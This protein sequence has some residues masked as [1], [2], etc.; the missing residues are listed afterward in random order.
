MGVLY[1]D[2]SEVFRGITFIF[3]IIWLQW[4]LA[5]PNSAYRDETVILNHTTIPGNLLESL[6]RDLL[7]NVEQNGPLPMVP[8]YR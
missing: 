6:P 8:M 3:E 7:D 1:Q 5:C 4:A 2:L